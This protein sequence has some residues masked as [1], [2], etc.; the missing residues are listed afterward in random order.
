MTNKSHI[1]EMRYEF[2]QTT[3]LFVFLILKANGEGLAGGVGVLVRDVCLMVFR[4]LS[5]S[6]PGTGCRHSTISGY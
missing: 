6:C 1:N 2:V 4:V 3:I 5:G